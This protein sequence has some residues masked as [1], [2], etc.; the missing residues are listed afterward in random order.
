L[1]FDG[2][3]AAIEET[4]IQFGPA[5]LNLGKIEDFIYEGVHQQTSWGKTVANV[6]YGTAPTRNYWN[7]CSTGGRQGLALAQRWGDEFD[8]Y[9]IGAPA[10]YW[11]KFRLA[12]AWGQI[13]NRDRLIAIGEGLTT[14]QVAATNSA[15]TAACDATDGVADGIVNDPRTCTWS[16]T[17]NICGQPGAPAAPNCL[18]PNQAAALDLIAAGPHNSKATRIWFPFDWGIVQGTGNIP[19]STAQVVK[20]N[21][22]DLDFNHNL[23]FLDAAAIAAA[24]NPAGATTYEDETKL[25][26]NVVGDYMETQD[27]ALGKAKQ[28]GAKIIM[29]QGTQDPAIRWRHSLDYHTRVAAH[30]GNGTPDYTALHSWFRYYMAPGV[31][32]C[33]GGS[34]PSPQNLFNVL[35]NWV[36][37]G[38]AP[39]SI[40]A[41]G[42]SLNPS[43][44]RPLCPFPQTSIYNGSGSTDDAANFHCGGN[45]QTNETICLGLRAKYKKE[46]QN[47]VDTMGKYNPSACNPKSASN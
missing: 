15:A 1:G 16:A 35:V 4:A 23:V 31:G 29:W 38:V 32:H 17:N 28:R 33:G 7:G 27:A 45:L 34:G 14:G 5:K 22:Q 44:T 36:E 39:D 8:G 46:D 12:D 3:Y 20:Y 21:H 25:G 47:A 6:Y 10:I 2:T 11:Q 30:F 37:N 13:V 40:L 43:R 26:S 42:G 9:I 41:Q 24:G 19:N 18:T